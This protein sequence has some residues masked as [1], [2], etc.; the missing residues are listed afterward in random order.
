[1]T[2]GLDVGELCRRYGPMVIRRCRRLLRDEAEALDASQDVFVRLVERRERLDGQYPSSLLFRIATNVCLNRLRDRGRRP[3]G[4]RR[5]AV[6]GEDDL[7]LRIATAETPGGL[8]EA[9]LLLDRLFGRHPESSRTM[10]VLHYVDGL[11]LEEVATVT[12][13]S[14][15]GVRKRLRGLRTSLKG[16]G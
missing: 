9:R 13:M 7:L 10:A 12:G 1:M 6:P 3:E 14:V 16:M 5:V 2:E 11:T 8:S 15:S 4:H